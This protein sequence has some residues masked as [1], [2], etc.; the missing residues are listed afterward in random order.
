[1]GIDRARELAEMLVREGVNDISRLVIEPV[2]IREQVVTTAIDESGERQPTWEWQTNTGYRFRNLADGHTF[3]FIGTPQRHDVSP[4]LQFW[5]TGVLLAWSSEGHGNVSYVLRAKDGGGIIIVPVWNSSSDL[6]DWHQFFALVGVW[7]M[8]V[9]PVVGVEL[10]ATL[11]TAIIG[12]ELAAAYPGLAAVVGNIALGTAFNGGDVAGAVK[13]AALSYVGGQVGA[14]V[15]NTTGINALGQAAAAATSAALAGGDVKRAVALSFV[16]SGVRSMGDYINMESPLPVTIDAS[17]QLPDGGLPL[18]LDAN[19][20]PLSYSFPEFGGDSTPLNPSTAV[21][22][23]DVGFNEPVTFGTGWENLPTVI[24]QSGGFGYPTTPATTSQPRPSGDS[25][26][27]KD[28]WASVASA[29]VAVLKAIPALKSGSAPV[30]TPT[31]KNSN[32]TTTTV[33]DNG[34]QIVRD[35]RGAIISRTA[36][37][38]G[39]AMMTTS[40]AMVVNNGNGTYDV[41]SPNGTRQTRPY[42]ASTTSAAGSV[43]ISQ[44][45]MLIG[46]GLLALYLMTKGR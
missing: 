19:E 34:T 4:S 40:G 32:G 30:T 5:D 45:H 39:V 41:V 8:A 13:G 23:V 24:T 15:I 7:A 26:S 33:Y 6:G 36:I 43:S 9:I 46:A 38:K 29:A 31:T 20:I 27:S 42:S 12:A 3:G 25:G 1:M 16:N 35:A 21:T 18:A 17:F 28:V 37:P 2:Q 10:A 44:T 11:G 22:V 14:G